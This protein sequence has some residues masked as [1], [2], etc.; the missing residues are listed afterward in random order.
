VRL[1]LDTHVF[2]WWA[3]NDATLRPDARTA[4][5]DADY[6]AVSVATAWEMAIK[7][8]FGRLE[9]PDDVEPQLER[10]SFSGL[11]ITFEHA[12]VAGTLPPHH[13]DPFDRMLV[14]Q[15]QLEGLTI[16]TRDPRISRYNVATL[17][18]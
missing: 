14:A 8:A 11:M 2:I 3:T 1:L 13:R 12:R 4:I 9:A 6:V 16:A 17:P 15:A 10:H 18:A 5:A 7:K